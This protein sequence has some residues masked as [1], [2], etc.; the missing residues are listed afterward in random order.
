MSEIIQKFL[1]KL[2]WRSEVKKS[3]NYPE[4]PK[5]AK[6]PYLENKVE[7][8]EKS[9]QPSE[10]KRPLKTT[11]WEKVHVFISST[12]NDMHAER[13]Y[14]VKQVF[15]QLSQ[16]CEQRK[17]RL[18]D[19]DLRWGVTEQDAIY[20]KNV[21]K[22]C[23]D[24]IDE[25]RPFF[26]CFLGQRRGWVPKKDEISTET[27][28]LFPDL[29]QFAGTTSVTEMEILH[30]L[31]KPLHQSKHLD[32]TKS[33]EYYEKAKYAFFYLRDSSYLSELPGDL[34]LLRET[35]TNEGITNKEERAI[36][37]E[38]LR[39]WREEIIPKSGRPVHS[40]KVKW[41]PEGL[42]PEFN[43][44]LQCPSSESINI[45]RWCS[46]WVKAGVAVSSN[47][48][49][50]RK[51][52]SEK[53]K[54]F[55][56]KLCTGRLSDFK[57]DSTPL[58][59][60]ILEDLKA[61]ISARYPDHN[62]VSDERDLQKEIDQ[63]E[64]FQ[65]LNSEG[66][67]KREG[68]FTELD[69]YV[70]GD[71]N[72]LFVLTAPGGMGKSMLLANWVDRS[73]LRI[74]GRKEKS[75]H[76]RFIGSSDRS[77]TIY[78]LMRF[79]LLEMKEIAHKLDEDIPED[80]A[81]LREA[82]QKML[83]ATGKRGMTIIVI[84]ALN[85]LESGFSDIN[86]L[87]W[88]LPPNIKLIVSFKR[89]E[90]AAEE[91]Y[92]RFK[93]SGQVILS[94]VKPFEDIEDRQ[95]LVR[96]YL[97]QYLKDLDKQHIETLINSPGASNPLYLKVVLSELRIFG[98]FSNLDK[99]I[100]E[101]FGETPVSAFQGVLNRLETDP[102]YSMI[103]PRQAVPL[104]FGLMAHARHGLSADE[105]ASL[106]IQALKLED[107]KEQ[108]EIAANTVH[109]F[110][111]Q[112][113][114]FLARRE[115]RYDF[116]YESFKNASEER[117]VAKSSEEGFRKRLSKDWHLM[118][119][120]YFG[121]LPTWKEITSKI[122]GTPSRQ[123]TVRKV[124]EL[125]Y[126][127]TYGQMWSELEG[128]LCDLE[129]VE[130]KCIAGMPFDLLHDCDLA[131]G[132]QYIPTIVQIKK[133]ISLSLSGILDRPQLTMQLVYN[134]LIWFDKLQPQLHSKLENA[135]LQLYE[136]NFWIS[137]EAPLEGSQTG[138]TLFIRFE[139]KSS[140]QSLSVDGNFLAVTTSDGDVEVRVLASGEILSRRH[141][142]AHNIVAIALCENSNLA[143]IDR[144]GRI[145]SEQYDSSLSG[146]KGER[147]LLYHSTH[148]VLSVRSDNALVAWKIN[149]L[150]QVVLAKDLPA[151][152]VV[153]RLSHDCNKIL[154]IAGY[155][156][157]KIGIVQCTSNGWMMKSLPYSGTPVV[158]ADIDSEGK[159]VLLASMDR[160]LRV[161][162]VEAGKVLAE[163]SYETRRDTIL[164]G[165][166]DKCVFGIGDSL[167][168][169]FVATRSGH[170]ACWNW[171]M[172][173]LERLEDWRSMTEMAN[174]V[175]F[176]AVP[177]SG[178]LFI[179]T[180]SWGKTITKQSLHCPLA[181]HSASVTRCFIT[182]SKK[183]VSA[184]KLDQTIR[185][186]SAEGLKPLTQRAFRGPT[187]I[188][189]HEDTDDVVI[190]TS[191]GLV[192]NQPQ[193]SEVNS[194][195]IF[196][197]FSEP[198]VSLFSAGRGCVVAAGKSGRVLRVH[199]ST[200]KVDILWHSTG[201][202]RQQAILPAG[203]AGLFYSVRRDEIAGGTDG[204][205]TVVSLGRSENE[206]EVILKTHS[207]LQDV[208]ATRNGATL[209][210]ADKSVQI[211]RRGRHGWNEVYYRQMPAEYVAFL[212]DEDLIAVVLHDEPWLEVWKITQG[213][214]TVAAI[215]LP[216]KVS[217]LSAMGDWIVAGFT[218]GDL[219]SARL[220]RGLLQSNESIQMEAKG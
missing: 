182:T 14:L 196:M 217:C 207:L 23:L 135:R 208:A 52:E 62:E 98:A 164:R 1:E 64:Q 18:V 88:Q 216:G 198:V 155:N 22:V 168:C 218:S 96:A 72:K 179:S 19:I 189:R 129:F 122:D 149:G 209:C 193:D 13:D 171:E 130:A 125:P 29:E 50:D 169:A 30:A 141:I 35:Y 77:T 103:N 163:I 181:R 105:L 115:G 8:P 143:Y 61:A 45:E 212:G 31:L 33:P 220:R 102:P 99:K 137:A 66:F 34:P 153:L 51:D 180:E 110:L 106:F 75:I 4:K 46:Q 132:F 183:I 194:K 184:S 150:E 5:P 206:E 173:D 80:P 188:A 79:L 170:I 59:T 71:S 147:L 81:K 144:D 101:D 65:F 138:S 192:W 107:S 91:L 39:K 42:T 95:K 139:I 201:F 111:R 49:E 86:W 67:I 78:S 211:L 113:R 53:A 89:G 109:L 136:R 190:G 165:A 20:N 133:A 174:L 25:C 118:L 204:M 203:D 93:N 191:E 123:P 112:V 131:I 146:R 117:Y 90:Q 161:F 114:P 148:G 41:N 172:D 213:L 11:K 187:A 84:D 97:S 60:V 195:D 200:D 85:Q 27:Y 178:I 120:E 83:Q 205:S 17:L 185:W 219:M 16:W 54:E 15:P 28:K 73:R 121:K 104:L 47:N 108:R 116:F 175:H 43:I 160:H 36:H 210:V 126:H 100:R 197:A 70:E 69:K 134:R 9:I 215:W 154:F 32:P 199:L 157:Q 7:V 159:H 158:D 119:T 24:R 58:S 167:G 152:L 142:N 87:P 76:F 177:P 124:A 10:I 55:N 21:V 162:D 3:E 57:C 128:T 166:P 92:N 127:E 214:P 12:F 74:E 44:P 37:E 151:P 82:W 140:I 26:L 63:Q 38:E 68:D 145:R 6:I 156:Q 94:E 202:Q 176:T 2:G 56:K 186:Y 40:Y 48:V